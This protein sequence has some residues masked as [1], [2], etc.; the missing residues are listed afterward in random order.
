MYL[1]TID[2]SGFPPTRAMEN[3]RNTKRFPKLENFFKQHSDKFWILLSTNTSSAK[4]QH[5]KKNPAVCAYYCR[6]REYSGLAL[7]GTA[8]IVED[9]RLKEAVWHDYWTR[10][11]PKGVTDPDYT[12]LSL[13]PAQC[14]GWGK[15]QRF[16]FSP[17][18]KK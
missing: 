13:H 5:I 12:V 14:E 15:S 11:Y 16:F 8:E 1:S 9:R 6:P 3:L 18:D 7:R 17:E 10:Y 4:I 2:E